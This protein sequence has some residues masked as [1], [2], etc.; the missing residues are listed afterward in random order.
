[1]NISP[2]C[3]A[4]AAIVT[5][6]A[7][8]SSPQTDTDTLPQTGPSP[9]STA[10]DTP[11][12]NYP[13]LAP[14]QLTPEAERGKTGARNVLISFARAIELR[15][16]QQAYD[17][18]SAQAK[19]TWSNEEFTALFDGLQDITVAV[20]GGTME[21]AAGTSYYTSEATITASDGDGRPVRLEGPVVLGRVNDVPGATPEQLRWTI[22]SINLTQTH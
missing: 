18:L 17:L 19:E 22:R 11:D 16:V 13:D 20:P 15:E 7:C 3:L 6:S 4:L 21:G 8:G 1:M 2:T 12:D 9:S 10:T 14:A 5:L